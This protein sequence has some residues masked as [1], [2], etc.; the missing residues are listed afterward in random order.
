MF[1]YIYIRL[2]KLIEIKK[3]VRTGRDFNLSKYGEILEWGYGTPS[4]EIMKKMHDK[5]GFDHDSS[6]TMGDGPSAAERDEANNADKDE[7]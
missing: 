7:S 2:D 6:L 3:V 5:Y 1:A 4:S